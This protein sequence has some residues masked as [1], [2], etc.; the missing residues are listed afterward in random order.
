MNFY[1]LFPLTLSPEFSIYLLNLYLDYLKRYRRQEITTFVC[2]LLQ[3]FY[4]AAAQKILA[5]LR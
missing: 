5:E 3:L 4:F 2:E 1:E